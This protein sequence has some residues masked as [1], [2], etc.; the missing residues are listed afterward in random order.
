MPENS[1]PPN[2]NSKKIIGLIWIF[3]ILTSLS[4]YFIYAP[5]LSPENISGVIKKY[6]NGMLALYFAF[7]VIRGLTMI[8]GTPFLLAGVILF[9]DSPLLLLAAFLASMFVTSALMFY[10]ADK[11]GF[12]AYFEKHYPEKIEMVRA[13]LNGKSGFFFILIWAFAP[14]TPT[15]LVCYVAGS[16]RM[17]F[18]K[19]IVPLLVGEAIICAFYIFNGQILLEKWPVF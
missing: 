17:R 10:L 2:D 9:K 6:Q 8:P 12:N 14:F 4:L 19:L 5:D 7:C 15:D 13:R 16:I 18:L 3:F 11:L 1:F